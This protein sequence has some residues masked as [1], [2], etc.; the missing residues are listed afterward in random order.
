MHHLGFVDS[1]DLNIT[2]G[3]RKYSSVIGYSGSKLA[4]VRKT[5]VL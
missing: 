2:S 4:Q 3:K 5:D 1:N